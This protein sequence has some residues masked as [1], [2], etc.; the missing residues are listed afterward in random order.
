MVR[1]ERGTAL[2][3]IQADRCFPALGPGEP[4]LQACA[5]ITISGIKHPRRRAIK[6]GAWWL[7]RQA[8]DGYV[9]L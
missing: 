8:Q 9:N 2:L 1:T 3:R 7:L 5:E 6:A 4:R